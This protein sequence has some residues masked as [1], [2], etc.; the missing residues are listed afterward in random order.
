MVAD[1]EL[2]EW[3]RADRFWAHE[4][5]FRHRHEFPFAPFHRDLIADFW[6]DDRFY[7]DLGFRECG[8]TTLVEEAIAFAAA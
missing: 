5:F 8:K 6:S 2:E 1:A 3:I 4:L 7:I